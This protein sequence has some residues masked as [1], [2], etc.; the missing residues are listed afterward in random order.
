METR[1]DRVSPDLVAEGIVFWTIAL[2]PLWWILGI[3]VIVYP[4]AGWYLFWRSFR[5]TGEYPL[6]IAFNLWCTYLGVWLG[7]LAL[8]FFIL[9]IAE[10]GRSFATL[11]YSILG[12]WSLLVVVWYAMRRLKVRQAVVTRAVCILGVGQ[13]LAVIVGESYLRVTGHILETSSL[14]VKVLPNL[15]A[16]IF[17]EASMYGYDTVVWGEE[18]VP[19]F[20]GFYYWPPLVGTVSIFVAMGA[21]SEQ[22]RRWKIL[23]LLGALVAVYFA[24]ARAGQ[25]GLVVAVLVALW[26]GRGRARLALQWLLVPLVL[27]SPIILTK[28]NEYFFLYRQDSAS[29]RNE[30]YAQTWEAFLD[31]PLF[32]YG[33]HG[34]STVM[35]L[36]LGSHSQLF[37]TLYQTG[38]LGSAV[39]LVTWGVMFYTLWNLTR[40]VP[41]LAPLLG[42][43]AGLSVVMFSG[44]LEAASVPVFL[45]AALLGTGWNRWEAAARWPAMPLEAPLP[46]ERLQQW[47]SGQPRTPAVSRQPF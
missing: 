44:E 4:A 3:Q 27:A 38:L 15:P 6:P 29:A 25:V 47:W 40:S 17:F 14:I 46:W 18:Y 11:V 43:W 5:H 2:V 9:G 13:L 23:G 28:L 36:P 19:R 21:L 26:F 34:R 10:T 33:T 31:S 20:S 32:G 7:S 41:A 22:D 35:D 42:A 39:L 37:S 1:P 24:A 30:I 16:R 8:N 12:I 45:L